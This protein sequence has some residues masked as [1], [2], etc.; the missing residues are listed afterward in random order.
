MDNLLTTN[1]LVIGCG[2]AGGTAA[3]QAADSGL[4]VIVVTRAEDPAESNTNYAQGG[5]MYP[6]GGEGEDTPDKA[7]QDMLYAG[8]GHC[9]AEAVQSLVQSGTEV[10][11]QVLL[12]RLQVPFDREKDG[13]LSLIR[14]AAHSAPRI[15]HAA[16]STGA[17]IQQAMIAAL[18]K[19]PRIRLL[20]GHTAVDLLT[21]A[22]HARDRVA[23][24]APTRCVGAYLLD[25]SSRQ[26]IRCLAQSTVLATGGLG[27]LFLRTTN[28]VGA[29]GD[30]VAMAHR[31]GARV[32]NSEFIQFHPT[33]FHHPH[34]PNFLISEAVRG[35]GARLVDGS[36]R[37]FM[38]K[39]HEEW[40]DLAPRDVVARGIHQHMLLS[41][42]ENVFLDAASTIS[43]DDIRQEFPTIFSKCLQYGVDITREPVPVVP[44]AHYSCGGV[45]VDLD[46]HTTIQNL[47]AV[48]EVSC[49]G[50]HGANRLA[51]SSLLEG[52]VWGQRAGRRILQ[53]MEKA[54]MEIYP[55]REIPPWTN[56]GTEDPDPALI[57]QDMTSIRHI[58][59]NYV[60]LE[61]TSRRLERALSEL[62]HLET[63]IERFYRTALLTDALIGLR[64]AV[65]SAV[66]VTTAAW[67]NRCSMG[68]HYRKN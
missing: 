22:H 19:H 28:P 26:V 50:V 13:S 23:I 27:Q 25:R 48:G 57:H 5:I 17:V 60:G 34:A 30:G 10:V 7:V 24:Y 39:Y 40:G 4:E 66:I 2:I 56:L 9:L 20:S 54:G 12:E 67:E 16:D 38:R 43:A 44:A 14:E 35:A 33:T 36:G 1:V 29:R 45:W 31:A 37:P 65:R 51:S 47:Y 59:W 41:G 55:E 68:C 15:L 53:H 42:A 62:R 18:H 3:L 49:S 61:R 32:I 52:I 6:A 8:H 64:N 11:D 21:P 58:M 63:E 46:G